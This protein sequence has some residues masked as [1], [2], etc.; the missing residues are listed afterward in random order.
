MPARESRRRSRRTRLTPS[1]SRSQV[2]PCA[3][4][5]RHDSQLSRD[6]FAGDRHGSR[7]SSPRSIARE[8]RRG[9]DGFDADQ[10]QGLGT[11]RAAVCR[12]CRATR[13]PRTPR[14]NLL[15]AAAMSL[16]NA[17]ITPKPRF[18]TTRFTA[19]ENRTNTGEQ[20][21]LAERFGEITN[22]AGLQSALSCPFV[23]KGGDE[24]GGNGLA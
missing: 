5:A 16:R 1:K 6:P 7:V 23:R 8:R 11:C 9:C 10:Q 12:W 22:H 13:R 18:L 21:V 24:N 2:E 3:P 4:S 19:S 17:P 14:L 20:V 15:S